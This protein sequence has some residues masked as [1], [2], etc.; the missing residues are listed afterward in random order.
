MYF[1]KTLLRTSSSS[2]DAIDKAI[3]TYDSGGLAK[4]LRN[5]GASIAMFSTAPK[6]FGYPARNNDNGFNLAAFDGNSYKSYRKLPTFSPATLAPRAH[7]P[8]L[9]Q[10]TS[11]Y[12]HNEQFKVPS[13]VGVSIVV[14]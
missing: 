10:P 1:Y 6:G 11:S 4:A 14:K 13:G 3:K 5:W 2:T 9:R 8:F 12:T 7:F